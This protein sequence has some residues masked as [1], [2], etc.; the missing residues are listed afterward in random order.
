MLKSIKGKI[1][2]GFSLNQQADTRSIL[3]I[4]IHHLG[5]ASWLSDNLSENIKELQ[6]FFYALRALVRSSFSIA[7]VTVPTHFYEEVS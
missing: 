5:S 2:E 6:Q 3:R 4:G 7:F 1:N